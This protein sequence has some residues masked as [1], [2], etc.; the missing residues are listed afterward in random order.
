MFRHL[1]AAALVFVEQEFAVMAILTRSPLGLALTERNRKHVS[2][3]ER[4]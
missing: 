4:E 2:A 3:V 1:A